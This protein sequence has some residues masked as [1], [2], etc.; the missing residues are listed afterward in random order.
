M[1]I[2]NAIKLYV[3]VSR[4]EFLT[5]VLVGILI[6]IFLGPESFQYLSSSGFVITLI[7]GIIIFLLM[8]SVGFMVNCLVCLKVNKLYK[9]KLYMTVN[10][11]GS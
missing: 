6:G 4:W 1:S 8:F 11:M 10:K 5:A 7:E 9:T 3:T 2:R